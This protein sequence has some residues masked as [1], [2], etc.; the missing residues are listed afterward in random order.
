MFKEGGLMDSNVTHEERIEKA[1]RQLRAAHDRLRRECVRGASM[2]DAETISISVAGGEVVYNHEGAA[3]AITWFDLLTFG[4]SLKS[5]RII[6]RYDAAYPRIAFKLDGRAKAAFGAVAAASVVVE[7]EP[8]ASAVAVHSRTPEPKPVK[9]VVPERP[10]HRPA[11][12]LPELPEVMRAV[13]LALVEGPLKRAELLEAI[14]KQLAYPLAKAHAGE[15]PTG[16]VSIQRTMDRIFGLLVGNDLLHRE[17]KMFSLTELARLKISTG[18]DLALKCDPIMETDPVANPTKP[19]KT[20]RTGLERRTHAELV[21]MW[22]NAVKVLADPLKKRD[23]SKAKDVID[24]ITREWEARA[25]SETGYFKWPTTEAKGG[26]GKLAIFEAEKEGMLSFLEYRVGRTK[27]EAQ[28]VRRIILRRVFEGSLPPVFNKTY[29]AEWGANGSP[30]RLHKMAV[31]IA[32]FARNFKRR[33]SSAY[34]DAIKDW[35]AD[36]ADLRL[37]FYVGK[38]GFGWPVTAI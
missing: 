4:E 21:T 17:N 24:E 19:K 28:V 1:D 20:G 31:S 38:F 18:V 36:L 34:D 33:K 23:H 32:A 2:P 7:D 30:E 13:L 14:G 10:R 15:I 29:M 35:E 6:E 3:H 27:G 22:K 26:N 37:N 5:G 16:G 8:T 9:T 25:K 12:G 11:G